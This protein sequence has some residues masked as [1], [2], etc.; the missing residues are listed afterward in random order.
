MSWRQ[1]ILIGYSVGC[2][3]GCRSQGP[4]LEAFEKQGAL[5]GQV[6]RVGS[7]VPGEKPGVI[8]VTAGT[9][10]VLGWAIDG[11]AGA[12]GSGVYV[13]VNGTSVRC[14]YGHSRPDVAAALKSPKVMYSGYR[15]NIP[16]G[17]LHA[18]LNT[19]QVLLLTGNRAYLAGPPLVLKLSAKP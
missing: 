5:F 1:V 8:P 14:E 16:A 2:L 17:S 12:P 18:G 15:C 9:V 13:Q 4:D 6:E 7:V 10:E 11:K 3:V 19:G